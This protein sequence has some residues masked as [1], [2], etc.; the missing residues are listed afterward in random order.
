M[1]NKTSL[2]RYK[3]NLQDEVDSAALYRELAKA[4]T[5]P[6]LSRVYERLAEVEEEHARF[7]EEK[8]RAP[9][10]PVPPRKGGW[11]SKT[12]GMLAKR[13]GPQFVLPTIS[14]MEQ[15]DAYGYGG[16]GESRSTPLPAQERSHV[17][18]LHTIVGPTGGGLE[19]AALAQLEGRHRAT[20]GNAWRAAVLGANDRL[21]SLQPRYGRCGG[22]A[23]GPDNPDHRVGGTFGRGRLHGNGR[24]D[25]RTG[26][27]S[28]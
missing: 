5:Q 2:D 22:G 24:V 28:Q 25:L 16:Q 14:V 12:L 11:R 4:E 21:L 23:L 15:A 8:L 3:D 1:A 26:A 9:G 19:G 17:R 20:S 13:F 6:G 7:W 27:F 10:E 18:L